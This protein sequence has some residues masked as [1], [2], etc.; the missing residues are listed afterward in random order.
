M[1]KPK[2]HVLYSPGTN[3]HHETAE[4]FRLAGANPVLCHLSADLLAGRVQLHECD[5]IALPGGFSFGDHLAAGR[6]FAIDMIHRIQDQLLEVKSKKIPVIGICNGFQILIQ[7]GLLP[8]TGS[9]GSPNAVLDRNLSAKFENRWI[10]MHTLKTTCI[11][12]NGL[13]GQTLRMPVAHAEGRLRLPADF[14]DTNT[15]FRYGS[16]EGTMNYP[17]NP[18]GSPGGR[19]GIMDPTGTILGLMPHPERAV[20]AWLGSE[21]G[22][23][24]FQCGIEAVL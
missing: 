24:I 19:A 12:T 8:G 17:E 10:E 22:L 9:I 16:A 3:C 20:Y 23:K 5:I 6:I 1:N 18:N 21:D 4:A 14:D 7:T 13:A 15:V 11:W 2:V